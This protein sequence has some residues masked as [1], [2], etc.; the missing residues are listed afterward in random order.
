MKKNEKN[1]NYRFNVYTI[2]TDEG[3]QWCVEYPDVPAVAGGGSTIDE[4]INEAQENLGVY[5]DYLK[6]QGKSFP[7]VSKIN[8]DYSGK[9]TLRMS[10]GLHQKITELSIFEGVSLNSYINEAL[11][12]KVQN[13]IND[14]ACDY[15]IRNKAKELSVKLF[16]ISDSSGDSYVNDSTVSYNVL[17]SWNY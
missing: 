1:L 7:V 12:E 8:D 9:V 5:L 4:A 14:F 11:N 16:N 3:I 13:D 15:L 6:K 10:K 2:D 17:T